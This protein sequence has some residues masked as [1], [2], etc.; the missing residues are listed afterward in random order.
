MTSSVICQRFFRGLI[1]KR[2]LK[3]PA[4]SCPVLAFPSICRVTFPFNRRL[5]FL[6]RDRREGKIPC[7]TKT[8]QLNYSIKVKKN[9]I[10]GAIR[11][12]LPSFFLIKLP[13]AEYWRIA[14]LNLKEIYLLASLSHLPA[15]YNYV[16]RQNLDKIQFL[17]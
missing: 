16:A 10:L 12:I 14:R 13:K 5:M 15:R 7:D 9:H 2:P 4:C 17:L 8:I 1:F 6:P 11:V 3:H